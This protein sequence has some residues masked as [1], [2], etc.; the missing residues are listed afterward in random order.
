MFTILVH[1]CGS[2]NL[3]KNW[4]TLPLVFCLEHPHRQVMFIDSCESRIL[5]AF[6]MQPWNWSR[7]TEETL[8]RTQTDKTP[9]GESTEPTWRRP[10]PKRKT[11][12]RE[13]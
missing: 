6:N 10:D 2:E 1:I 9:E 5:F 8:V 4:K 7:G 12:A 13:R 3:N 11:R